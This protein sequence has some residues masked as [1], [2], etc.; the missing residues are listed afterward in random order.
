MKI[1]AEQEKAQK[2]GLDNDTCR[3]ILRARAGMS[4]PSC[5]RYL[6]SVIMHANVGSK[7]STNSFCRP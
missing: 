5:S 7:F 4:K 2:G 3:A 6:V 1:R